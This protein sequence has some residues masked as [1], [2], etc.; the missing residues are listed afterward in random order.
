LVG[1]RTESGVV[2]LFFGGRF[3]DVVELVVSGVLLVLGLSA[4]V[5]A[6]ICVLYPAFFD[7]LL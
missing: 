6:L 7:I 5:K 1:W 3:L 2:L 4:F